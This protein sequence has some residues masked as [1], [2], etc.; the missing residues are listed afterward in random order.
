MKL[1]RN[2]KGLGSVHAG[3]AK[4]TSWSQDA[5]AYA[6]LINDA[7]MYVIA[8]G[9]GDDASTDESCCPTFID[10]DDIRPC[11]ELPRRFA[12]AISAHVL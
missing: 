1:T 8:A 5:V 2:A 10:S 4:A 7:A 9:A 12:A 6:W 11:R 3:A